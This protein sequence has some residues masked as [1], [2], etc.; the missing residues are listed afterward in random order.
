MTLKIRST[1]L[2]RRGEKGSIL[3]R[4]HPI[5]EPKRAEVVAEAQVGVVALGDRSVAGLGVEAQIAAGRVPTAGEVEAEAAVTAAAVEAG[6]VA[7]IDVAA[8]KKRG[9]KKRKDSLRR[10]QRNLRRKIGE[11]SATR[12]SLL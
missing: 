3:H 4:H 7:A 11:R 1:L 2:Q 6:V 8:T 5:A 9:R 12:S 10:S